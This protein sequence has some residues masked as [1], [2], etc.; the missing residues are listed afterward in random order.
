MI[1][2]SQQIQNARVRRRRGRNGGRRRLSRR[3]SPLLNRRRSR[4]DDRS[5]GDRRRGAH[6]AF[7]Q[8]QRLHRA[9]QVGV[10]RLQPPQQ[11]FIAFKMLVVLPVNVADREDQSQQSNRRRNR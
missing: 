6:L 7:Q 11:H 10:L 9:I 5:G 8:G 3:G 2:F 4:S 1:Q